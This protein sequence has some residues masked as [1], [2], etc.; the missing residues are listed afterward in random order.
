G[1]RRLPTT[2]VD[3]DASG[4]FLF[5]SLRPVLVM[6]TWPSAEG[7]RAMLLHEL[8]H[9]R[10]RDPLW[11]LLQVVVISLF[12]FWPPVLWVSR[13]IDLLREQACDQWAVSTGEIKAGVFARLLVEVA[14]HSRG[15]AQPALAMAPRPGHLERRVIHLMTRRQR[16]KLSAVMAGLVVCWSA[17][18]LAGAERDPSKILGQTLCATD[19]RIGEQILASYPEADADGDGSLSKEEVCAHQLRMQRKLVDE[20]VSTLPAEQLLRADGNGDGVLSDAELAGLKDRLVVTV[21]STE[22]QQSQLLLQMESP[23]RSELTRQDFATVEASRFELATAEVS[24]AIC[25]PGIGRCVEVE[26]PSD[27]SF[28]IID[29]AL[30]GDD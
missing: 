4:A 7:Q 29:V 1:V 13:Q 25:E 5:G 9:I 6:P 15:M 20:V 12:F 11:R 18:A 22:E 19:P 16:P 14:S 23:L 30:K 8:A 28:L 21:R 3:A 26:G 10:R 27:D 2:R 17:V 24:G